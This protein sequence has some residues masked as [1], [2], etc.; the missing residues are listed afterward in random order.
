MTF[1]CTGKPNIKG[2]TLF[3][4]LLYCGVQ[5]GHDAASDD[6]WDHKGNTYS[7]V[8]SDIRKQRSVTNDSN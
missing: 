4:Y 1:I 6:T 7:T 8:I 2:L 5:Y 3:R